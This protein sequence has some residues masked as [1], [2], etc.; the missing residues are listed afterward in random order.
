MRVYPFL[1]VALS[2]PLMVGG[3]DLIAVGGS[4][5]YLLAGITLAAA[6]FRFAAG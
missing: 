4:G 5:Y 1:L 3:C 2:A 6:A